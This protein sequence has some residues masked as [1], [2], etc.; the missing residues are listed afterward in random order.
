M[1]LGLGLWPEDHEIFIN[2]GMSMFLEIGIRDV[3]KMIE[4]SAAALWNL[5]L[6]L[7][8]F[9]EGIGSLSTCTQNLHVI[10]LHLC[11]VLSVLFGKVH[12]P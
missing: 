10:C 3:G 8:G 2:V 5:G 1:K 6:D 11:P 12:V 7:F 4:F 9:D